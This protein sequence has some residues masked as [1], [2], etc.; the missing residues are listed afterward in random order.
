V[1]ENPNQSVVSGVAAATIR[2]RAAAFASGAAAIRQGQR[3]ASEGL[4]TQARAIVDRASL[5]PALRP[6]GI[7]AREHLFD[8]GHQFVAEE[9]VDEVEAA[10]GAFDVS[11]DAAEVIE[12]IE[13][14][15]IAV[16]I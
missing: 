7:D 2:A 14:D 13:I 8:Q 4:H 3:G 16:I 10:E 6:A 11:F 1:I 12:F 9:E 15:V 5:L